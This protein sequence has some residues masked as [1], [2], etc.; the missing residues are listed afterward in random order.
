MGVPED[1]K[2]M[3]AFADHY[4]SLSFG[5]FNYVYGIL[6]G[7]PVHLYTLLSDG[8]KNSGGIV[9]ADSGLRCGVF[10][11]LRTR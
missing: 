4:R 7:S 1:P 5:Y 8:V 9:A 10:E 11:P 2:E 3:V 6:S